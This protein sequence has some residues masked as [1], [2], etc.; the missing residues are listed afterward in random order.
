[1]SKLSDKQKD[2]LKRR[3][4]VVFA[5][6]D[7]QNKPRSVFVEVNQADDE[8]IIITDNEMAITKNNF[9]ENKNVFIMAF[10]SDY[11]YCLKIEGEAEYYNDGKYFDLV[12]NLDSNKNRKPKGAII[13]KIVSISEFS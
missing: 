13:I 12:I 9:L 4:I 2:L 10:E 6:S 11:S 7:L 1:M 8:E 3:N 5:T